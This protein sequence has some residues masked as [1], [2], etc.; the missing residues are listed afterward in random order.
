M[1]LFM[2]KSILAAVFLAASVV[3]VFSM[4]AMMGKT[5]KKT[6]PKTLRFIHK[7]AGFVF[8]V[9][10][11]VLS[12]I[13]LKYWA[14]AGDQISARATIHAILSFGLIAVFLVK[15]F[16]AQFYKQLLRL[17]PALGIT[18]FCLAFVV[19][20]ISAGYYLLRSWSAVPAA[21]SEKDAF[22]SF[23]ADNVEKGKAL[24]GNK[25]AMCHNTDSEEGKAGP[26][27]KGL[28]DKEI[29]PV[30]RRSATKENVRAQILKPYLG[31][32]A[33]PELTDREIDALLSYISTL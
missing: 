17:V 15:I 24:F 14:Q 33:F 26:G 2:L 18:V 11:L 1:P 19:T 9:L 16:I 23:S 30:S 31:M 29:L 25:C 12:Y 8:F 5:E 22:L 21:Q 3:A 6:N 20:G 13:C 28:L 10:L 4:L 7:T 32:P 27:L